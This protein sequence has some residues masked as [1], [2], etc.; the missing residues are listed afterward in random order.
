MYEKLEFCPSCGHTK[1]NN[2][3]ILQDFSVSRESFA[4]CECDKCKLL[5]INP[6]PSQDTLE[7][8]YESEDYISHRNQANSITNLLY[9]IVRSRTLKNKIRL[10]EQYQ[11][12]G[13]LLD[14]GAGTGHFLDVARKNQW[15]ISGVEPHQQARDKANDMVE[16][17]VF[18][19]LSQ[20]PKEKNYSVIT[21]WHVIEHVYHLQDTLKALRKR[22]TKDGTMFIALPNH[23]S[24]D[25]QYYSE[26]WAGY[27]VPRH[28][29]HFDRN[30][31][32]FVARKNKLK[33]IDIL[34]MKFDS[35]YVSLL[36]ERYKTNRTRF[37]KAFYIGQKSNRL[38]AR[39]GEYSSLIYVIQ[40]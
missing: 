16:G 1:F 13:D 35:Y 21:A 33:I 27:D 39:S 14:Y 17:T 19:D 25:S 6:R 8:Y 36:S 37:L 28:L 5:F 40:R 2:K 4:L 15:N 24:Y 29:Y 31:F 18:E 26:Y 11:R 3:S 20:L 32:D 10:V 12:P 9:K 38:A 7:H 34:P 22:L 30:T 23:K